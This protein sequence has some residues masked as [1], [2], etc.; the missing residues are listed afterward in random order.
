MG[1]FLIVSPSITFAQ[2]PH[3]SQ[4][5]ASPLYMNPALAGTT[6][7]SRF[8]FNYRAQWPSLPGEFATYQVSFDQNLPQANSGLGFT[9]LLDKAGAAGVQSVNF[10]AMYSYNLQL[11]K[12][13]GWRT[14]L[15]IGFGNRT[16]D[17][18]KLVFGD[19]LS[20][21]GYTGSPTQEQG[22][23]NLNIHYADVGLG[24]MLYADDF[25]MGVSV[26]HLN[27]PNQSIINEL[28]RLSPKYSVQ[29]GYKLVRYRITE[30][31]RGTYQAS[32]TPALYYS[33]QGR[34]QQLD[35]GLNAYL[36]P[37]SLGLWYRGLPIQRS[38]GGAVVAVVGIQYQDFQFVYSYDAQ[39]GKRG[40]NTGGAH[41]ITIQLNLA[42]EM[43]KKRARRQKRK[44]PSFPQMMF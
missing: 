35:L 24:T 2:D 39:A 22:L 20:E 19:Q 36:N 28:E 1:L 27:R 7:K 14:G 40:V 44:A 32:L 34:F 31:N 38:I 11:N 13:W 30:K 29:M 18:F 12:D 3:F 26:Y 33:R 16:L 23:E 21:I 15:Q 10:N 41:E 8:T 43:T 25:W 6:L 5:Y 17:Y 4:F 42:D 37:L 9:A